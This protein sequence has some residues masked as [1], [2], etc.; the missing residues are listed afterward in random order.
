MNEV[1][2]ANALK[3]FISNPL[4]AAEV[5][6]IEQKDLVGDAVTREGAQRP[7][8]GRKPK[9]F[10]CATYFDSQQHLSYALFVNLHTNCPFLTEQQQDLTSL[11]VSLQIIFLVEAANPGEANIAAANKPK[12]KRFI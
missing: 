12:M 2:G 3:A 8:L 4:I 6:Q 9:N 1:P 11:P 10:T 7:R 5:A